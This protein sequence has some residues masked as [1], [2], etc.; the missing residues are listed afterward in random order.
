[1]ASTADEHQKPLASTWTSHT[2]L[3]GMKTAGHS[4][5]QF[6]GSLN[7]KPRPALWPTA[8]ETDATH[9]VSLLSRRS[10]NLGVAD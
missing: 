10:P 3:A 2:V 6:E 7:S 1:M 9:G 8:K 5:D 4:G